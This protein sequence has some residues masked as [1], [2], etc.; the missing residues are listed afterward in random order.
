MHGIGT[1]GEGF[2]GAASIGGVAGLFAVNH[3]GGDREHR[4]RDHALAVGRLLTELGH[5]GFHAPAREGIHP[6]VVVAKLGELALDA[7]IDRQAGG[8]ADDVDPG[9]FHGG[10]RVGGDRES[11]DATRQRAQDLAVVERHLQALVTVLVVHVV[12]DVERAH[13]LPGQPAH[14]AFKSG[15]HLFKIEHVTTNR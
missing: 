8:V 7:V 1:R 10:E 12:D 2:A 5:E 14:H 9:V 4:L 6:V 13:I 3:V 11:G 15:L